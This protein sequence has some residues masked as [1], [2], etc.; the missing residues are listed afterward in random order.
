MNLEVEKQRFEE[1]QIE[2]E[3]MKQKLLASG[4]SLS[5]EEAKLAFSGVSVAGARKKMED[6]GTPIIA[7]V[8]FENN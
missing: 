5:A 4:G 2:F 6:L 8:S 3:Q 7:P 1:Q